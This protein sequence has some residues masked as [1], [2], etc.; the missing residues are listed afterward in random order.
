M[1]SKLTAAV[2][3][4]LG[5]ASLGMLM[6]IGTAA[7]AAAADSTGLEG[8]EEVVVTAQKRESTEQKTAV[9]MTILGSET[10]ERNGVGNLRDMIALAPSVNYSQNSANVIIA[11][12]GVSSRDTTEIGDPAVSI[13]TDGF[14]VQRPIGFAESIYD[15]E[16]VEVLRGPQGTLYG[17]NATGGAINF[18]TAKPEKEFSARTSLTLGNYN[19]VTAEGMVNLPISDQLQARVAVYSRQQDGFR[20]NEDPAPAGDDADAK[21]IRVHLAYQPTDNFKALLSLQ[22]TD[23]GGV[24]PTVY[25]VRPVGALNNDVLP[26]I[27]SDGSPHGLPAQ[28]IDAT[29]KTAQLTLDYN[30]GFADIVYLGG[31]RK[32]DY[33]QRRDLDGLLDSSAY[34]NPSETPAD[35]SH[36]LRLVSNGDGPFEWQVGGYFF[37]EQNELLTYFQ[38]YAVPN[39]PLN[40][41]VFSYDVVA[42]SKAAFGQASYKVTDDVKLT[43]GVRYSD[44]FKSRKG[45]SNTGGGDVPTNVEGSG[46]KTTYHLGADWQVTD[47]NMLYVK[48]DT[49][50]K[51]GGFGEVITGGASVPY[52]Y[53]PE[54]IKAIEAGAK[55]RF[56]DNRAQVNVSVFHYDYEDQ[57]VSVTTNGL[58]Q[59]LNAGKSEL[60]G[61]ELEGSL[62]VGQGGRLDAAVAYLEAEFKDFCT[63]KVNGVCAAGADFSGNAPPQAPQRQFSLGYE[64]AFSAFGGTLTPRV[65]GRYES[66]SYFGI[67]N[68]ERQRQEGYTKAD[69]MLT[70]APDSNRWNVQGYVRNIGDET[71]LTTATYSGLWNAITFGLADPR[72]YGA[73]FTVNW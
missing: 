24:G 22:Y 8:L 2:L 28:Y 30:L 46:T 73:R 71:V 65:Q 26:P 42:R 60:Y 32:L 48:Y 44:D 58:A 57:Q 69:A 15:L 4:T 38:S 63:R 23:I 7:T 25:G 50:Y 3:A 41:F 35:W 19:L 5:Q 68:F 56:L 12:R 1:N 17:R 36:E 45:F 62:Q 29:T 54:T 72:T 55:N 52:T 61:L 21:S 34:F 13:S 27:D 31:Y 67:E 20:T 39:P 43:A 9:A 11:V 37:D 49:G 53:A 66:E 47:A 18:I 59:I 14:Y 70:F 6:V 16:R 51:A 40:R 64:H 33:T 10:L